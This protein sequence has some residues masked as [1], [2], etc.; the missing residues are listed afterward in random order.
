[1]PYDLLKKLSDPV[2]DKKGVLYNTP[3]LDELEIGPYA[4]LF[5]VLE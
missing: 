4:M 5:S 1:M 3:N 2:E